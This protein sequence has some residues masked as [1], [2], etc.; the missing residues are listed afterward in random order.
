MANMDIESA[1][2]EHHENRSW[3]DNIFPEILQI[4]YFLQLKI[5]FRDTLW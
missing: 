5:I 2:T 1:V 3:H 4:F